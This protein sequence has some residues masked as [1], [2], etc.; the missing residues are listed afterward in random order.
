[1]VHYFFMNNFQRFFEMYVCQ[2]SLNEVSLSVLKYY[3][4]I[5]F[6]VKDVFLFVI[7]TVIK[8]KNLHWTSKV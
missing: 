7:Q 8:T 6:G 2:K 1:M 4:K 3:E 5:K